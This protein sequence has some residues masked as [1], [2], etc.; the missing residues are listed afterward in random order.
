MKDL[1]YGIEIKLFVKSLLRNMVE[2]FDSSIASSLY[3]DDQS[4]LS[5]EHK[6]RR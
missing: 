4:C 6:D 3:S 2:R 1:L 5:E